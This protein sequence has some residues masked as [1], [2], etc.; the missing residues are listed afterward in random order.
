MSIHFS[1]KNRATIMEDMGEGELDLLIIG[2]GITGAGIALDAQLRGLKTGLIEMQDFAAGT[3]SRSTKLVHGGL[4]YLKQLEIKLVAEVGRE[5]AIVYE[6]APHVTTPVWMMLPIYKNGTFG[7]LSTSIGLGMYD[8]LARVKKSERRKMLSVANTMLR[9]PLLK[10]EDLKGSGVYVEYRTDD[11]R[12]TLEIIKKAFEKGVLAANYVKAVN[13]LYKNGKAVGVE[14]LDMKTGQTRDIYAKKIVNA[15]GP[16]VD[17]LRDLDKSKK[18]KYLHLTKGVHLV[19]DKKRFPLSEAVYFDTPYADGRMLFAIPRGEKTYVG[20]TDTTYM[21]NPVHPRMTKEDLHYILKATNHLFPNLHLTEQDVESSWAGLRPLIHEEGK[22]P[23][24][25]S[26]KDEIFHS[27]TGLIT[28]AGGKL[29]G[30]RKM[31]EKVVNLVTKELEAETGVRYPG[32]TTDKMKLSGGSV[33][34]SDNFKLYLKEQVQAGM[35]LGLAEAD[36]RKLIECYGS[37]ISFI[38]DIMRKNEKNEASNLP[39]DLLAALIYG[40]EHEMVTSPTDFFL[41]RTSY[42]LFDIDRVYQWKGKVISF[43]ADYL[44]WS[45]EQKYHYSEELEKRIIDATGIVMEEEEE[46]LIFSS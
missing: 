1:N 39:K 15:T 5:R 46:N 2:G 31:A 28:I 11:A 26:R 36:A 30:Y 13:F 10:K 37:N 21:E 24:D 20:T 40:I 17:G 34:G 42:L 27:P 32:C 44:Q 18:G 29:T 41:R 38:Y 22:D 9:E 45:K 14:I 16:W 12:L 43:M 19:I 25:I 4:R 33:G 8:F 6:N 23:S 35:K 7:K 3:S